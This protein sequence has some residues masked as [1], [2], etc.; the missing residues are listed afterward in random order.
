M[1][2]KKSLKK[3]IAVVV[4]AVIISA[5]VLSVAA[6]TS[7]ASDDAANKDTL[8][9]SEINTDNIL[10]KASIQ[11]SPDDEVIRTDNNGV[12]SV[13]IL[14]AFPVTINNKGEKSVVKIAR[15]TVG[16]A[17]NKAGVVL[18]DNDKVTPSTDT[19]VTGGME[20][21][22]LESVSVSITLMGEEDIY[23]V[24]A[25][26][27]KDALASIGVE[28]DENDRLSVSP[29][30]EVY[31]G[32]EI[33]Y[34][35]VQVK[36]E[37]ETQVVDYK[38]KKIYDDTLE[39]GEVEIQ[40]Y[41]AE[42]VKTVTSKNTY[43]DG[44]LV[45]SVEISSQ[46]TQ[47]PVTQIKV[48]GTKKSTASAGGAGTFTDSSGNTVSFKR[49]VTGS[50]TAYTAKAGSSTATGAT[51]SVGCVAVNPSVIP[52]GS[53]LYITSA[54]GSYV[55]G[56]ATAVDTGGALMD[57]SAVVDLFMNS[58][59]DCVAFGRRDVIVYIL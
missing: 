45:S 5:T 22:I 11:L 15:G 4:S 54:D 1:A 55:Y 57:G 6:L 30:E 10:D 8:T 46:V 34:V 52:Y 18:G 38:T 44:V 19:Q 13:T 39:K 20:I 9:T 14:R 59:A 32:M 53:K 41:G 50:G 17:L 58:Y 16:D 21:K 37:A 25:G 12:I 33:T 47:K 40:R 36:K 48:I 23:S 35:D 2:V 27:V 28:A 26:T 49:T 51:V 7:R 42:G 3:I 43:E 29:D 24:P 31:E 56:Y